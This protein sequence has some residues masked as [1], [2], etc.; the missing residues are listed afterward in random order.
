[1]VV[2]TLYVLELESKFRC[3]F[4]SN[5]GDRVNGVMVT[6]RDYLF[7]DRSTGRLWKLDDNN[8]LV[9]IFESY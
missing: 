2:C 3:A 6:E 1:M 7:T 5:H 4:Y 9:I 8:A